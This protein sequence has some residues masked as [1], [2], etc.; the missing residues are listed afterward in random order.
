MLPT[1]DTCDNKE[2][3]NLSHLTTYCGERDGVRGKENP[4]G[5]CWSSVQ[6]RECHLPKL[7]SA[8]GSL[9]WLLHLDHPAPSLLTNVSLL[10]SPHLLAA[11]ATSY[12]WLLLTAF[13]L[14]L[15][16]SALATTEL[17][18]SPEAHS[19]P[20]REAVPA[21]LV[22]YL[23]WVLVPC[24]AASGAAGP[25]AGWLPLCQVHTLI[26]CARGESQG[27]FILEGAV[28]VAALTASNIFLQYR[29]GRSRSNEIVEVGML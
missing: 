24:C 5:L 19:N 16:A 7:F 29:W 22:S 26:Q 1:E 12:S 4:S 14:C 6:A 23:C 17:R 2:D 8:L 25:P 21:Q 3:K 27:T 28:G 11:S 20:K 10:P 13:S 9:R 15:L 18:L